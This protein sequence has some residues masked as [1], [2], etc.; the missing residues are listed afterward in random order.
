M[1]QKFAVPSDFDLL[2][3]NKKKKVGRPKKTAP[4]FVGVTRGVAVSSIV[5]RYVILYLLLLFLTVITIT[6]TSY[7]LK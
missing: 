6:L 2:N 7:I 3:L 4:A 1:L 5:L